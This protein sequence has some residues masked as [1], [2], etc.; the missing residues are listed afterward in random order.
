MESFSLN[1]WLDLYIMVSKLVLIGAD[2]E[3]A[4]CE[5]SFPAET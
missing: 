3:S 2:I 1:T 4:R 5:P